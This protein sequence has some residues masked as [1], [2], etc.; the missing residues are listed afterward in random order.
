VLMLFGGYGNGKP[1]ERLLLYIWRR[2]ERGEQRRHAVQGTGPG[3]WAL[4]VDGRGCWT[5]CPNATVTS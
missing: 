2:S 1:I 5:D 4:L 3:L